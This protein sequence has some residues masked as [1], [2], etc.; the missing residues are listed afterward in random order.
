MELV[1]G[2]SIIAA[3]LFTIW[4]I[5]VIIQFNKTFKDDE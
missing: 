3:V 4:F 1:L 2:Y 5:S